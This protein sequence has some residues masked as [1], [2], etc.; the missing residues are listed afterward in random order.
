[1]P[2]EEKN[3][4]PTLLMVIL[5]ILVLVTLS[6]FGIYLYRSTGAGFS[7]LGNTAGVNRP[8]ANKVSDAPMNIIPPVATS[9]Y[10]GYIQELSQ[11]SKTIDG[12]TYTYVIGLLSRDSVPL[13]V[14]ITDDE[15]NNLKVYD[16]RTSSRVPATLNDIK[17]GQLLKVTRTKPVQ[18]STG[19]SSIVVEIVNF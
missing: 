7:F 18:E 2:E 11:K 13:P 12:V 3:S 8:S 5:V 4:S 6:L 9:V 19:K 10:E 15:F 17:G 14:W 16:S 1:M